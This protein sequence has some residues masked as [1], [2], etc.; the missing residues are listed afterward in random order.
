[1]T[2]VDARRCAQCTN[3]LPADTD[4]RR[5]Y[6]DDSCQ[7]QARNAHRREVTA[8]KKRK[9]ELDARR[10]VERR[11]QLSLDPRPLDDLL[12]QLPPMPVRA[13]GGAR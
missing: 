6:C 7:A 13:A 9:S 12:P 3:R 8:W 2:A 10:A 4:P 1:M 5:V 11:G